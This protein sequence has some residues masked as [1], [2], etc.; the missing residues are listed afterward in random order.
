MERIPNKK[1]D[2][3]EWVKIQ[4]LF[5]KKKEGLNIFTFTY[6]QEQKRGS[7]VIQL[8]FEGRHFIFSADLNLDAW[9]NQST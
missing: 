9:I 1:K 2:F 3:S 6:F 5:I 7:D 4:K 8:C